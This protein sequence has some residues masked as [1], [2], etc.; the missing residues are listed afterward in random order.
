MLHETMG[1][2]LRDGRKAPQRRLTGSSF[3]LRYRN[4]HDV[5]CG[6][7]R[8]RGYLCAGWLQPLQVSGTQHVWGRSQSVEVM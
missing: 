8:R 3:E 1:G 2:T 6:Y 5:D 4:V 7:G